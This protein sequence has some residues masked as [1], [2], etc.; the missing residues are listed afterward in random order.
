MM[1]ADSS[2]ISVMDAITDGY[3]RGKHVRFL[4]GLAW[5]ERW[6]QSLYELRREIGR[7]AFSY[8]GRQRDSLTTGGGLPESGA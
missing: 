2:V 4:P 6:N 7:R 8:P 1:A 3:E 5:E